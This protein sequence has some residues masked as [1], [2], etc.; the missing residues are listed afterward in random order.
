MKW[1]KTVTGSREEE[2]DLS[3]GQRLSIL[4]GYVSTNRNMLIV[5]VL[6]ALVGISVAITVVVIKFTQ[7]K[8]VYVQQRDFDPAL[9]RLAAIEMAMDQVRD[10]AIDTRN[11]L[12]SSNATA[13]KQQFLAQE[14]SYQLHLN[15]LKEGM[16]ELARMNP[17][18]RTWLEIYN[19]KMDLALKQSKERQQQ[20]ESLQTN[21]ISV[22][23]KPLDEL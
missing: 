21:R 11:V 22:N 6:L 14:K 16:R 8:V 18:S 3:D 12:D 19:E 10:T 1:G 7:P 17:G 20:L 15:A 4:E 23:A 13:F 5:M 9:Q 2:Y